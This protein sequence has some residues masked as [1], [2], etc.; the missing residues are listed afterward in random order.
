MYDLLQPLVKRQQA[1]LNIQLNKELERVNLALSE[2]VG[3]TPTI[4]NI[5]LLH[6]HI[7]EMSCHLIAISP[8]GGAIDLYESAFFIHLF[9]PFNA[10]HQNNTKKTIKCIKGDSAIGGNEASCSFFCDLFPMISSW[11]RIRHLGNLKRM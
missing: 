2:K 10:K 1:A 4:T 9:C 6:L 7:V 5:S 11:N 3:F 8:A